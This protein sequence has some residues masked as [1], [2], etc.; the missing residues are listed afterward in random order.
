MPHIGGWCEPTAEGRSA[1]QEGGELI[2]QNRRTPG[3]HRRFFG[4]GLSGDNRGLFDLVFGVHDFSFDGTL[5]RLGPGSFT[6]R[7]GPSGLTIEVLADSLGR[8][9]QLLHR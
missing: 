9:G 3:E 2:G 5:V 1:E 6:G 8:L 7:A 4:Q